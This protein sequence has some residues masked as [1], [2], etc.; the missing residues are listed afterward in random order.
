[1]SSSTSESEDGAGNLVP[2]LSESSC[3]PV[4]T[5]HSTSPSTYAWAACG[6][7]PPLL[8]LAVT[9]CSSYAVTG[10][11]SSSVFHFRTM[12]TSPSTQASHT[13]PGFTH[14]I[15]V[16]APAAAV[17]PSL[18]VA[19]S[20]S[21]SAF[22]RRAARAAAGPPLVA[23]ASSFGFFLLLRVPAPLFLL[24]LAAPSS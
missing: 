13:L 21:G 7:P 10:E 1:D 24:P 11:P 14:R 23:A 4:P 19:E 8:V 9:R 2:N 17:S 12:A 5:F 20:E 15:P 16:V 3:H 6:P 18:V 22:L